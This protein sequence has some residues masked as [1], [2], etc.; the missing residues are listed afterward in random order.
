LWRLAWGVGIRARYRNE[1]C[2]TTLK[3]IEALI[4]FIDVHVHVFDS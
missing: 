3:E 4:S 2:G 1:K